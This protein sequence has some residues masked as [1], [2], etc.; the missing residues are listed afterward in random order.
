MLAVV[1]ASKDDF[2]KIYPLLKR[3]PSPRPVAKETWQRLLSRQWENQ[4]EPFG[5]VLVDDTDVVGYIGLIGVERQLGGN[6]HQII[7]LTSW[8]VDDRYK[9]HAMKLLFP[10]IRD[11][12]K[13]LTCFT[14]AKS[15]D[16]VLRRFGFQE[17][18]A[19][20]QVIPFWSVSFGKKDYQIL[21]EPDKIQ[22]L[23]SKKDDVI[24]QDHRRLRCILFV[25]KNGRDYCCVVA[26]RVV[27]KSLPFLQIHYISDKEIFR[28]GIQKFVASIC[29]RFQTL[30]LIVFDSYLE[31]RPIKGA[32]K[33]QM[34][35]KP[36]FRSPTL[37]AKEMDSLYSE[38]FVLDF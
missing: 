19:A 1:A 20:W 16:A 32:I 37:T 10:F 28:K 24:Y 13:T 14:P 9:G 23:L 6:R 31:H 8:T 34:P 3:I 25:L 17:L 27:K 26:K 11:Q 4:I 36:L 38:F 22:P 33:V 18:N 29:Q 35:D 5:Y 21:F 12:A 2:E 30:G 15:V 7:G